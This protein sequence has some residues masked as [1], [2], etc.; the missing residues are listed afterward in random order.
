M[1]LMRYLPLPSIK[2]TCFHYLPFF[3][4]ENCPF[5][6]ILNVS[7]VQQVKKKNLYKTYFFSK[8]SDKQKLIHVVFCSLLN[9]TVL[10]WTFISLFLCARILIILQIK[11]INM[12]PFVNFK[13]KQTKICKKTFYSFLFYFSTSGFF[14]ALGMC[15]KQ[16]KTFRRHS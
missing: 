8:I 6:N 12:M 15:I 5:L 14:L 11:N 13:F 7:L 2:I 9:K 3:Y 10:S 4:L 16:P 1:K